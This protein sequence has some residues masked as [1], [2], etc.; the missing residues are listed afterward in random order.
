MPFTY[1]EILTLLACLL[2][3]EKKVDLAVFEVGM[4]GRLDATHALPA[5]LVMLTPIHFDHEAY[6]GETLTEIAREKAAI[7]PRERDVVVAPQ[8]AEVWR[9][10]EKV[11]R[12]R[13]C[14]IWPPLPLKEARVKLL[15]DFQRLNASMALRAARLLQERF[16]LPVTRR[17]MLEGIASNHWPGRMELFPGKPPVLIDGA[18]NPKSVEVLARNLKALFPRQRKILIFGTS[19]DKRSERMLPWLSK[20]SDTC[21]LTQ[22]DTPRAKEVA[23]LLAQARGLFPTLIPTPSSKEAL[24]I[25]R[26]MAR[27]GD[28]IVATGSFYLIGELRPLCHR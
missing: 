16:R 24:E 27:P 3:K 6:L 20:V 2:F 19:R 12:K 22:S 10:I 15:G 14:E 17:G 21:I 7:L 23:T 1:F 8:E 13:H 18:H 5:K 25:A 26:K 11:A 28:L 4:G 9:V